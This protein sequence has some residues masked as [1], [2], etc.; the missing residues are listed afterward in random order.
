MEGCEW[1]AV[2]CVCSYHDNEGAKLDR[3][4]KPGDLTRLNIQGTGTATSEGYDWVRIEAIDDKPNPAGQEESLAIRYKPKK[5]W[6]L[7]QP[8]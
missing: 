2:G 8:S 3:K 6:F 5:G 7:R 4:P 1:S